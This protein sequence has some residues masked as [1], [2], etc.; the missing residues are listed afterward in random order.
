M[1]RW[2]GRKELLLKRGQPLASGILPPRMLG[3]DRR[4]VQTNWSSKMFK[5][6]TAPLQS[7]YLEFFLCEVR[8]ISHRGKKEQGT[9]SLKGKK[10]ALVE[11]A[12]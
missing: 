9:P 6:C 11:I 12:L 10:K 3:E 5:S 8:N 2:E 7:L 4:V 1:S